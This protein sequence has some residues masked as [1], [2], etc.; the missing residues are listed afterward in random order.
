[1]L[2]GQEVETRLNEV[3]WRSNA[4]RIEMSIAF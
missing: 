1:L 2:S 4:M 3:N